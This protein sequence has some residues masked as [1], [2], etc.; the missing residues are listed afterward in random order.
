M[1]TV[2]FQSYLRVTHTG[3]LANGQPNN[4]SVLIPDMD[5]GYENQH[6]KT[7]VY[8]PA[9]GFI[10]IPLTSRV[11]YSVMQGSIAVFCQQGLIAVSAS[12]YARDADNLGGA[13]TGIQ[14]NAGVANNVQRAANVLT[15]VVNAGPD[16]SGFL[17]GE[18]LTVVGLAGPFAGLNGT[19]TITAFVKGQDLVGPNPLA[20]LLRVPSVGGGLGPALQG[21]AVVLTLPDGMVT[22]LYVTA[23]NAG[24][25]GASVR[26]YFAGDLVVTGAIDPDRIVFSTTDM[27][28][29]PPNTLG[30]DTTTGLLTFVDATGTPVAPA[31]VFPG[32]TTLGRPSTPM[33]YQPYFDTDLV[34]PRPI[35]WDGAGWV[36]ATG[37]GV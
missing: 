30:V 8:V 16:T 33:L 28:T 7:P 22:H 23:G 24:G 29:A 14:L 25:L 17:A 12:S 36:D 6:R 20:A 32:G 35:W 31:G 9:G 21:P 5:V 10:D 26:T 18:R 11:L 4:N 1:P 15:F 27:T 3:L 34:P 2:P 13:G 37:A 19:Y